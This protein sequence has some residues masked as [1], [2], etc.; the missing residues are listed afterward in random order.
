VRTRYIAW[1]LRGLVLWPAARQDPRWRPAYA[2]CVWHA[3]ALA[4][5]INLN[6]QRGAHHRTR[7]QQAPAAENDRYLD[8]L[9]DALGH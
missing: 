6:V 2:H 5:G 8:E 3:E 9:M 1:G 7:R 4:Y